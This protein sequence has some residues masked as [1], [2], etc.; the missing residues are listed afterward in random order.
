MEALVMMLTSFGAVAAGVAIRCALP[1]LILLLLALP[2][3]AILVGVRG[4]EMLWQR[5]IG[6]ICADRL[7]WKVT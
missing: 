1:P 2:V 4:A 5:T 3:L 7:L 6:L